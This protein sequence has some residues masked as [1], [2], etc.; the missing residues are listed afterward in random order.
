MPFGE[1]VAVIDKSGKVVNTVSHLLPSAISCIES[2][3]YRANKSLAS[4]MMPEMPTAN[5]SRS[6]NTS[7]MQESP[8]GKP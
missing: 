2:N 3:W 1:T 5:A 7:A 6:S 4:S 8:S